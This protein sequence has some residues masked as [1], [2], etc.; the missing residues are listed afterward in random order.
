MIAIVLAVTLSMTPWGQGVSQPEDLRISLV[1][2]SPGDSLT[3][4]W[5][6]SALVVEDV[7]LSQSRL[8]N[9]GMFSVDDVPGFLKRFMRGRLEF[10]VAEDDVLRTFN[11]YKNSLNRDVRIQLLDLTSAEAATVA[12]LLA[13]N[14]KPE[15]ATYL[16]HHY[17]DNC[18]TRPR[19]ILDQALQGQISQLERQPAR[20]GLRDHTR[21][22][23]RVNAPM[24]LV[25]DFLQNDEL[26][27]PITL[28]E[29]AFL[30]DELEAQVDTV[31]IV[32]EGQDAKPLVKEKR[33]WFQSNREKPPHDALSYTL[34]LLLVG[35]TLAGTAV[36]LG[37]FGRAQNFA[38][39]FRIPFALLHI[40]LGATVGIL[41]LGLFLMALFTDQ[42]VT[43]RN[44]N[45]FLGNPVTF[46][47]LPLGVAL[48]LNAKVARTWLPRVCVATEV[49]AF[50]GLC[51]KVFSSFDQNNWNL[52]ALLLPV[53]LVLPLSWR[54]AQRNTR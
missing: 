42:S 10:W 25:L 8:Y 39:R 47:L 33:V 50:V 52:M 15:N 49:I 54:L 37:W 17:R 46:L 30:P 43:H 27:Q 1:T 32:R 45:L 4:W 18:S 2:F 41:G 21:R 36:A 40:S 35:L 5:G 34:V 29:E 48:L 44:E 6:H 53:L 38:P 31:T 24:S 20:M 26:D 14:V 22:Y 11:F 9:Y 19:D 16:Y 7:R 23:S 3:E 28:R 13:D 12:R 51:A